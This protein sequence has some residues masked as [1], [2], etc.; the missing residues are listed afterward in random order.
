M[1]LTLAYV[2]Y[3][4]CTAIH[5]IRAKM[6]VKSAYRPGAANHLKGPRSALKEVKAFETSGAAV[7]IDECLAIH[8][9]MSDLDKSEAA[10]V[11]LCLIRV[12]RERGYLGR[13]ALLLN[14]TMTPQEKSD[15][16][17]VDEIARMARDLKNIIERHKSEKAM[18]EAVEIYGEALRNL[19]KR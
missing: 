17:Y 18:D 8:L 6:R 4:I 16:A 12:L 10:L 15:V 1:P 3:L 9:M 19:A 11:R 13:A 7:T 14:N 2:T 5:D